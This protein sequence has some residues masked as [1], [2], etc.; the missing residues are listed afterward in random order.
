MPAI[1]GAAS[2][3]STCALTAQP[4]LNRSVK[5]NALLEAVSS[6]SAI[7]QVAPNIKA[8]ALL[9]TVSGISAK[10]NR[11]FEA[12]A[13]LA[14]KSGLSAYGRLGDND[15][16]SVK[17]VVDE[18]LGLWGIED[19]SLAKDFL[20][21]QAI[22]ELNASM[23]FIASQAKGL[24]YLGRATR[25]YALTEAQSS[26]SLESDVQNIEGPVRW[27]RPAVAIEI[28][29]NTSPYTW[30]LDLGRMEQGYFTLTLT[31]DGTATAYNVYIKEVDGTDPFTRHY[32]ADD[33]TPG[34]YTNNTGRQDQALD[35]PDML[36]S[37]EANAKINAGD[38][39]IT[40]S[41]PRYK[42]ELTTSHAATI[43]VTNTSS[44][45]LRSEDSPLRPV[46][47]RGQLESWRQTTGSYQTGRPEYYY[48]SR[49]RTGKADSTAIALEVR[50]HPDMGSGVGVGSL[51]VDVALEPPRFSWADTNI[52]K[53]IPLPH[54]Y[55][56]S[57]FLPVVRQRAMVSHYYVGSQDTSQSIQG[58][59]Q[60]ALAQFGMVDPQIREAEEVS[61]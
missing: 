23:Q 51:S 42:L 1:S 53:A 49:T 7:A 12:I 39:M 57:L 37:F 56:E 25:T 20:R 48:V 18:I 26:V 6:L 27:A 15:Y 46:A 11:Q 36:S 58:G 22:N 19:A 9:E 52:G 43:A 61:A 8:G 24:D 45:T 38:L 14:A 29:K 17:E 40:G 13:Y 59:Y 4:R 55:V 5:G 41:W 44:S 50:P 21:Q 30:I 60:L 31:V 28:L 3:V 32:A 47:T 16:L 54:R 2:L 35:I 33:Q 34:D 10:G